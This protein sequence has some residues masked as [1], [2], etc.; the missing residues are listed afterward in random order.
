MKY[1]FLIVGAGIYGA[2]FAYQAAKTGKRCLVIDRRN[3]VAGDC[4]TEN[5]EGINVH[6]HGAH[7]FHTSNKQVW[8]F[9]NQFAEF[10]N[11]INSPLAIYKDELYN[12]PFN[13]NTFH[14]IWGVTTP[15]QAIEIIES[16]RPPCHEG[17]PRNLEEQALQQV[18]H[19]IY[20]KLIKEY[21]E[22]QW[23]RPAS[24]L[25]AFLI[26]RLPV[27][28]TYDNNYFTDRYQG[29]PIGGYTQIIKKLLEG[30]EVI[31]NSDFIANRKYLCR[32]AKKILYTG[33]IDEYY[34]YELGN[35]HYRSLRF[36]TKVLDEANFQGNAVVNHI[37]KNVPYTRTIEHKHFE[38]GNQRK[39]VVTY[40]YPQQIESGLEPYYPINDISNNQLYEDYNKLSSIEKNVF[41]GGR[42]GQ[43]KY[44][45]MDVAVKN[46]LQYAEVLL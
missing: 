44:F 27:R 19:E 6:R 32:A 26:N 7:I 24:E 15:K 10:N 45:D 38:Y 28:F 1:D 5:I 35:L 9:V 16:Q 39:T 36:E 14:K 33:C 18:G 46:A 41:F 43:Y 31:L 13:M 29:I 3:H 25:P 17:G 12:L 4:Y 8:D 37:S 22:K 2:A 11:Y 34:N 42:L 30:T 23:G 21:T 40:E 20:H